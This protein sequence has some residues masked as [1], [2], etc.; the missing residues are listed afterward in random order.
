VS[1]LAQTLCDAPA[2]GGAWNQ[3]DVIL[4]GKS[5]GIYR[6]SAA[7][8]DAARV[9]TLDPARKE[10]YHVTP[11]Y[12]PDGRHFL[13][14]IRADQRRDTGT[15]VG[16][17]DAGPGTRDRRRLL[18]EE[19][20]IYAP[21]GY[22]I[23]RREQ[24]LLAQ[25]FDARGLQLTGSPVPVGEQT[26]WLSTGDF[27]ASLNGVLAWRRYQG[28]DSRSE[29]A[30]FD[31][32]GKRLGTVGSEGRYR[33]PW[34][35]PDGKTVAV[36]NID[37]GGQ[38]GDIWLLELER[39]TALRLTSDP[40]NYCP[41]WSPD[42]SRIV[43]ASNRKS[44]AYPNLYIKPASGTQSEELLLESDEWKAP[45]EITRFPSPSPSSKFSFPAPCTHVSIFADRNSG[46]V[47]AS[48]ARPARL[49]E[50]GGRR[51]R[52]YVRA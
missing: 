30:W 40:W 52:E 44:Y 36:E 32:T 3:D 11:W 20:V 24:S 13:F 43:F 19:R 28:L 37:Q 22:L 18:A 46:A 49:L 2:S 26:G 39:K 45:T 10:Q 8:G 38:T 25:P 23:F 7:G 42:G 33:Q 29:L 16:S 14:S 31:R 48:R 17:L 12:L 9:T 6:V 47:S 51:R 34:L 5:D 35:A 27:S 50:E 41:I 1:G 21:P 15:F 4:F